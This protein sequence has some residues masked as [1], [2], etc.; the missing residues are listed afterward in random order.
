MFITRD[1]PISIPSMKSVTEK[2]AISK[3]KNR[4][5]KI[6]IARDIMPMDNILSSL[7]CIHLVPI[8]IHYFL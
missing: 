6:P 3:Y 5:I 7:S 1:N 4:P 8:F 2:P